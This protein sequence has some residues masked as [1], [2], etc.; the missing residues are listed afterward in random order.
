MC[1]WKTLNLFCAINSWNTM[2]FLT[3]TLTAY[4]GFRGKRKSIVIKITSILVNI[5]YV[6]VLRQLLSLEKNKIKLHPCHWQE[7]L[8]IFSFNVA[9]VRKWRDVSRRTPLCWNLGASFIVLAFTINCKHKKHHL[10]RTL[11]TA[12]HLLRNTFQV[13][14]SQKW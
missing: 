11:Y 3:D 13:W 2:W 9:M 1:Q 10:V 6:Q 4:W 14:I 7:L 5:Y 8:T 12:S